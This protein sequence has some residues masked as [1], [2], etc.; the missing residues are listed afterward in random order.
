MEFGLNQHI[1]EQ[2]NTIFSKHKQIQKVVVYG[3]R[4]K[5]NYKPHSDIDLSIFGEDITLTAL[6]KIE[7]ELDDLLLPYKIDISIFNQ[8]DNEALKEHII[9]I[10]KIFYKK[11]INK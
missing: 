9:R 1:I 10:G 6:Q 7:L 11:K 8:I 5:G 3:S 2:L 4:A